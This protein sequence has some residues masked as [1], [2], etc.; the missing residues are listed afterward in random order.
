[1]KYLPTIVSFFT[2]SLLLSACASQGSVEIQCND[3]HENP[4]ITNNIEVELGDEFT[5]NLC[6]NASTGFQWI[7]NADISAPD[8]LEQVSHEY[9]AP[10]ENGD[11]P[12][13]GTPG[14]Q[15]WRFKTLKEGTSILS[16]EYSRDWEGGEK[17]TWT[18]VLEVEVK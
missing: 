11:P 10:S 12:P 17:G 4:H 6:S 2:L 8:I 1:M 15:I 7:E 3:F 9:G 14:I 5:V 13:P 18:F 16:F